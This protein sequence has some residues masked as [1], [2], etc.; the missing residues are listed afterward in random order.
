MINLNRK[1]R[2]LLF[3]NLGLT[4]LMATGFLLSPSSASKRSSKFDLLTKADAVVSIRISGEESI[5]LKRSGEAWMLQGED[6]SI[7]ADSM[8]IKAFVEAVDAV[9]DRELVARN[10]DAWDEL[11]LDGPKAR[12]VQLIDATGAIIC[13]FTLGNYAKAPGAVYL[14]LP[15]GPQ[16]YTVPSG[17]ASY[18]NGDRNSWMD[19]RVWSE[20]PAVEQV[21][22]LIVQGEM[23][24]KGGRVASYRATRSKGAW[25]SGD[26]SLDAQKVEAVLRAITRLRGNDYAPAHEAAGKTAASVELVL[27]NGSSLWL[28]IESAKDDGR[29]PVL[30]S[31]RGQKLFL[32]AWALEEALKPLAA[33]RQGITDPRDT[34]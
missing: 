3:I 29:Y 14:S 18:I 1:I 8:R 17:M 22:E 10:K 13:G 33:L 7:P 16:A 2:V 27:G 20:A 15:D 25:E 12:R 4:L 19:L 34:P 24:L 23:E 28:A 5:E 9:N 30:S 21:Q 6:G 11:G 32:P 31:Q 26:V